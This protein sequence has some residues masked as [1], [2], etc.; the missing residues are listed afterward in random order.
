MNKEQIEELSK[1]FILMKNAILE[2]EAMIEDY[3][4]C[5]SEV[6]KKYLAAA[7]KKHSSSI[8]SLI[9]PNIFE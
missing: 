3:M 9:T 1:A 5:K 6:S 2:S 7:I 4:Q 8:T